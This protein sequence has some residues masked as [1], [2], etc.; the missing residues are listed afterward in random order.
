MI[1]IFSG[2]LLLCEAIGTG[3]S[4]LGVLIACMNYFGDDNDLPC[5]NYYAQ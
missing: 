2:T 5:F 4:I 3:F 1:P